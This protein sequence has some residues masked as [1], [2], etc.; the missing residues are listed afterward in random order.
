M[1]SLA[2]AAGGVV[3]VVRASPAD[4]AQPPRRMRSVTGCFLGKP[5]TGRA[6]ARGRSRSRSRGTAFMVEAYVRYKILVFQSAF[7]IALLLITPFNRIIAHV[8]ERYKI[9]VFR[10]LQYFR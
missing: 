4:G 8:S 10:V 7:M 2:A 9:L 3:G 1:L 5:C 6:A